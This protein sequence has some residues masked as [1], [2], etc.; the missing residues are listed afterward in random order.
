MPAA[1]AV[2]AKKKQIA[3]ES[4]LKIVELV[5]K[6]VKPCDI[7]TKTSIRNAIVADL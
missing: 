2:S 4:G 5:E 1:S 7:I 6:D 3:F